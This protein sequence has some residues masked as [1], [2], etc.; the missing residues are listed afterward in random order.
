M[1]KIDFEFNTVHGIFKDALYLQEGHGFTET[2]IDAM[3]EERLNSWLQMLS[4]TTPRPDIVSIDGV[5]YE[6][7]DIDGQIVLKPISA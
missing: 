3:K 7:V 6:K 1:I 2:E 4:A 5:D